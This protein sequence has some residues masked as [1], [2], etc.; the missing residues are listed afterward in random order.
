[1][2]LSFSARILL[3][4]AFTALLAV[5][6]VWASVRWTIDQLGGSPVVDVPEQVVEACRAAPA[7]WEV[8]SFGPGE[9]RF[10]DTQ[11]RSVSGDRIER[12][13]T[14]TEPFV[15]E[16]E[17]GVNTAT[18]YLGG[19]GPCAIATFTFGPGERLDNA[20]LAGNAL[21]VFL[22]VFAS[23]LATYRFTVVPLLRRIESLREAGQRVGSESYVSAEDPVGDDLAAIA[24]V[25]DRSQARILADRHELVRRQEALERY[26]AEIAHD[27]RTPLGSLLLALQEVEAVADDDAR[28]ASRR[29]LTDAAYVTTLVENL[30]QAARLRHGLDPRVGQSDLAEIVR[31]VEAR[32]RAIG[33][34]RGVEVGASTDVARA[35][36]ACEPS[37]LER[38]VANLVHNATVHG[39]KH[40]AVLLDVHGERFTLSVLDDGP[41]VPEVELADLAQRTFS[42]DPARPRGPGMGLGLA[43]TNELVRRLGWEVRYEL[44]QD[45]GLA[46]RVEGPVLS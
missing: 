6:L 15:L 11:G 27:L 22:A 24:G 2:Q 20:F 12:K 28:A 41:G 3:G 1:M 43:I 21:G 40:V 4:A 19:E 31:R 7:D 17:R 16:R 9:L 13:V 34:A 44:G 18:R 45:G 36:V 23:M 42:D 46:V 8:A 38:A 33:A 39:A 14:A 25:L 5:L 30:H 32:F 26:L 37:L 10:Y 29:A 35:E